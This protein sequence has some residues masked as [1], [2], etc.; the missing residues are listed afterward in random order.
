MTWIYFRTS[1]AWPWYALVGS[2]ITVAAGLA[3]SFVYR[4]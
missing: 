4:K 3:S 2:A 1:L